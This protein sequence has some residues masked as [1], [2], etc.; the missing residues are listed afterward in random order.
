MDPQVIEIERVYEALTD[1]ANT[2][3]NQLDRHSTWKRK[4]TFI[5]VALLF[6][7]LSASSFT[8]LGIEK[9]KLILTREKFP[10]SF[11]CKQNEIVNGTD[12]IKDLLFNE[13]RRLLSFTNITTTSKNIGI[14]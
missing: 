9:E 13:S 3:R 4:K 5:T 6:T 12:G 2:R 1:G 11:C 14:F 10:T 8:V 7:I